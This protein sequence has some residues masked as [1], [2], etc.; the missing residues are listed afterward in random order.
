MMMEARMRA[1][2][3]RSFLAAG[4]APLILGRGFWDLMMMEA[5]MRAALVRSFLY[6]C[7]CMEAFILWRDLL[8]PAF[9]VVLTMLLPGLLA[10]LAFLVVKT[11]PLLSAAGVTPT[12]FLLTSPLY[13]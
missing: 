12:A 8:A 3:V 13:L 6:H 5:R 9:M 4:L 2:L 10:A 7:F 1:A 11:N